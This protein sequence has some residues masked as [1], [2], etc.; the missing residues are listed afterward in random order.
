MIAELTPF[1]QRGAMLG[2]NNAIIT[3]S[4]PLAP[5]CM[6]LI[7]DAGESVA[8]GFQSNSQKQKWQR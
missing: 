5:V 4:G 6:G 8:D 1:P 3:L 7:I 2:I